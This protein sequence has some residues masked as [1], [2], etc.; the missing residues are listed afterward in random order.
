MGFVAGEVQH[1]A[2]QH[3]VGAGLGKRGV[4]NGLDAKVRIGCK[5]AHL[6]NRRRIG[7]VAEHAVALAQQEDQVAATTAAGVEDAHPRLQPSA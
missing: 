4:L 3:D 1:G 5:G 6:G 7:V 2:G